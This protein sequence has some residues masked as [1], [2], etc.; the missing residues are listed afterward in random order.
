MNNMECSLTFNENTKQ[1]VVSSQTECEWSCIVE[2]GNITLNNYYGKLDRTNS[3]SANTTIFTYNTHSM[4][5][6]VICCFQNDKCIVKKNI[7]IGPT[8]LHMFYVNNKNFI[9]FGEN[10]KAY[11]YVI[12]NLQY[13]IIK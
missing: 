9:L 6:N 11:I 3:Y 2:S 12:I 7:L 13:I 5:G 10:T 4:E 1:I 8:T